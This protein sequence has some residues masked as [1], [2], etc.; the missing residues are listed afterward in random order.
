LS[1]VSDNLTGNLTPAD[2]GPATGWGGMAPTGPAGQPDDAA[3]EGNARRPEK[4]TGPVEPVVLLDDDG[5][6]VG[7][8]DK[9]QVHA[10]R[11]PLHL[12]F[13]CYVF[14]ADGALL[15]TRRS[16]R[17]RTWPGVWT[18]TCCGHPLPGEPLPEAVRRRL[19]RELGI[20]DVEAIALVLPTFRYQA[21]MA[22]GT[23]E[24]EFCPVFTARAHAAPDPRRD[25]VDA[26]EWVRWDRF[27]TSVLNE[28]RDVAPWCR[29]QVAEL[30]RLG[31]DPLAWSIGDPAELPPAARWP[32]PPPPTA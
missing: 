9:W 4:E 28:G 5:R 1:V 25:E 30:N 31:P 20:F 29:M 24:N 6:P 13:S 22:D 32:S 23:L 8:A 17:K 10:R 15:T 16:I 12:A 11:T 18:N 26:V 27:A 14:D 3:S 19:D 21:V 7:V 2:D